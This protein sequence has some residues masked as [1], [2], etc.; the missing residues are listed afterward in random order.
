MF[1]EVRY[2]ETE[3]NCRDYCIAVTDPDRRSSKY[4]HYDQNRALYAGKAILAL[5]GN[6][7]TIC[8]GVP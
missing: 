4:Y 8:V 1:N 7:H 3:N 2:C 5:C 6:P